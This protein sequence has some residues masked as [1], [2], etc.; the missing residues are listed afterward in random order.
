MSLHKVFMPSVTGTRRFKPYQGNAQAFFDSVQKDILTKKVNWYESIYLYTD[1]HVEEFNAMKARGEKPSLAGIDDV[2][3]DK[4]VFDFDYKEKKKQTLEQAFEEARAVVRKLLNVVP[5]TA[6]RCFYSGNKGF[7]V[8]VHFQDELISRKEFENIIYKYA[9]EFTEAASNGTFDE[10]VKDHQRLFRM[11]LSINEES[12]RYKIPITAADFLDLDTMVVDIVAYAEAPVMEDCMKVMAGFTSVAVPEEFRLPA[13]DL[14]K[15]VEKIEEEEQ[16]DYQIDFTNRPMHLTPAKYVL[17]QGHFEEGE[18]NEACLILASTYKFL[19]WDA[20]HTYNILKATLRKR[21]KRL[22]MKDYDKAELWN[23]IIDPIFGPHWKGGTFKD[24]EGLLKKIKQRFN[25]AETV[26]A[27]TIIEI[28]DLLDVTEKFLK[29]LD[30]NRIYTG[31]VDLDKE[32]ILTKGMLFGVLGCP[33]SGKTSFLNVFCETT[34]QKY[35]PVLYNSFDMSKDLLG[36]KIL[37]R[38][39]GYSL[40]KLQDIIKHNTKGDKLYSE[41]RERLAEDYKNVHFC[42]ENGYDIGMISDEI[43][44]TE[45]RIGQRLAMVAVDYLEKVQ[46]PYSD[47]TANSGFIASN[48]AN[49]AKKHDTC[50]GLLLQPSKMTGAPSDPI[51][52]YR[53]I[54]GASVIE[55]DCRAVIGI[56]RPGYS[57]ETFEQD[58]Y[59]SISILKQNMGKLGKYDFN[60]DGS[61]GHVSEMTKEERARFNNFLAEVEAQKAEA[62]SQGGHTFKRFGNNSGDAY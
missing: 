48:L 32:L 56:W 4:V 34:S 51:K 24:D 26:G 30:K 38:Y 37:Q 58:R 60:W 53:A 7:H 28:N 12:K 21:A 17:Q 23:T 25:L 40:E 39:T 16:V 42:F 36:T 44:R 13:E 18:R 29:N 54:K 52:S 5:D 46:G 31:L 14:L 20:D 2:F 35:G 19:G 6:V 57:P 55:Q 9:G 15:E 45:D 59:M 3:T 27:N 41:A 10:K 33:G 49:L 47:A 61:R 62:E 50:I 43:K 8:E 22:G 1:K 11:P